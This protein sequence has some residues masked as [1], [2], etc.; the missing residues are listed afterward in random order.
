MFAREMHYGLRGT[1]DIHARA[2]D[3]QEAGLRVRNP[4]NEETNP[5][6]MNSFCLY[7]CIVEQNEVSF[8]TDYSPAVQ[9]NREY[10]GIPI[11][12]ITPS[13]LEQIMRRDEE[14]RDVF[15]CTVIP[16]KDSKRRR[17]RRWVRK[18]IWKR[19]PEKK[20]LKISGPMPV[21]RSI[22]PSI[23]RPRYRPSSD[24][25]KR[26]WTWMFNRAPAP[27]RVIGCG[28]GPYVSY[29]RGGEGMDGDDSDSE[30]ELSNGS[31]T[32]ESN[33]PCE[34][35]WCS[36]LTPEISAELGAHALEI[37]SQNQSAQTS[38]VR[39]QQDVAGD[40]MGE[41]INVFYATSFEEVMRLDHVQREEMTTCLAAERGS[42]AE[43]EFVEY[44]DEKRGK[45]RR[46]WAFCINAL[47]VKARERYR[48]LVCFRRLDPGACSR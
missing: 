18:H 23:P 47:R 34:C 35:G 36:N 5:S 17:F 7:R 33:E 25:V 37:S 15:L 40:E 42:I 3:E 32:H 22:E 14:E 20:A 24:I 6:S 13:S 10:H 1:P 26:R 43:D 39:Q 46:R 16:K 12:E 9:M 11:E 21:R 27:V 48:S 4:S 45:E 2:E 38:G 29:L 19:A 28:E 44:G 41:A 8:P 30:D 31:L